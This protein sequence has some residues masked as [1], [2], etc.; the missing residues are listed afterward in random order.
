ML[1]AKYFLLLL[2][3]LFI[4]PSLQADESQKI[5]GFSQRTTGDIWRQTMQREMLSE[6][7]LYPDYQLIIKDAKDN[8][9]QQIKDILELVDRGIDLL[10][11][12]PVESAPLT[13]IVSEVY[14]R[15]IPVI[16]I[17]S[18]I[19]SEDYT[20][21]VGADNYQIGKEAG[22]YI[23]KL[24]NGKGNIL[25]IS[26]LPGSSPAIDRHNGFVESLK[27]FPGIKI[28]HSESGEWNWEGA[29]RVIENYAQNLNSIDLIFAHNDFMALGAYQATKDMDIA[30]KIK[31]VGIDGLPG[32]EGG[33]Q[34]VINKQLDATFLYPTGGDKAIELAW[35]ILNHKPFE[36]DNILQTVA[37]DSTNAKV[38]KI[39]TDQIISLHQKIERSKEILDD[40][41]RKYQSQQFLL[42]ISLISLLLIMLL[43]FLVFGAYKTKIEAN[44]KLLEQQEKINEQ[45]KKLKKV[46]AQLAEA[47]QTKLRFFTNI[48]HEFRTPLTLILGPLENLINAKKYSQDDQNQF[49][50]MHR[51][52]IRLLQLINQLM[53]FR[54]IEHAKMKLKA[55]KHDFKQFIGDIKTTFNALAEQ[56]NIQFN[57]SVPDE[58]LFLWF[59]KDMMDK[60]LFNLLSN[61]FKFTSVGGRI[62]ILVSRTKHSFKKVEKE[63]LEIVVSDNGRGMSE[64]HLARIFDRF[65]QAGKPNGEL[66]GTGIGLSLVKSFIDLHHGEIRVESEPEKGAS[67]VIDL[68]MGR[69]HLLD[70]EIVE[71]QEEFNPSDRQI[72]STQHEMD[73]VPQLSKQE[74]GTLPVFDHEQ[75]ILL[76]VEDNADVRSFIKSSLHEG[77]KILEASNGKEALERIAKEEPDLVISDVMMPV[78]NGLEFT[79]RLKS[80]LQTCHIPVILLTARASQE[81][82][83]EGL[84]EGADS[85]IPKPF[86]S[87]HLQV[88]VDKLIETRKKIRQHYRESIEIKDSQSISQL[89]KSFL[90]KST[91][92]IYDK[93]SDSNFGVEELS[94]AVGLSRVHLYRKIKQLTG[95]SASEFIRSVKLKKAAT[96]LMESKL[97]IA[98]IADQTG[99]SSPSYFTK[100]FKEQFKVSPKEYGEKRGE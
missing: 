17:D 71:R 10:I 41:D 27:I 45:N 91:R 63:A 1:N 40:Q 11:V 39:Q 31:F 68:P 36:K 25:E 99:F 59:D 2:L 77:Y 53:D 16:L 4:H 33:I 23:A 19:Q 93:L 98:E 22:K 74:E 20:A 85:Y 76:I 62:D 37:I 15:G 18:K 86:N 87:R 54:K 79:R 42:I 13:P 46:S 56:K 49:R 73:I 28:I 47:T 95:L 81:H 89:D 51:N 92:L 55:G 38:I 90:K 50:L 65:Y 80:N 70:E 14:K 52:A 60:V 9:Q 66:S 84:E 21:F 30:K 88:R 29:K 83:I 32:T 44:R 12:S 67:F 3:F 48:S 61:A 8:S 94:D 75:P 35:K 100:C 34:Y 97:S 6:L 5:I 64:E 7:M 24:I 43:A 26:G 58:K 96:L 57:L 69:A 78:M 82:K 72:S